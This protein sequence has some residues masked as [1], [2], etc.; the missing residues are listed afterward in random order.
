M[1][2]D[3]MSLFY[4]FNDLIKGECLNFTYCNGQRHSCQLCLPQMATKYCTYKAQ[5]KIHELGYH[6]IKKFE[7][8]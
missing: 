8:N 4:W 7:I 1:L 6:L 5:G 3:W 2:V